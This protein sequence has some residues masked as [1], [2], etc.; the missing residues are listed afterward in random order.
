MEGTILHNMFAIENWWKLA[1]ALCTIAILSFIYK[2]NVLFKIAES[3]MIGVAAGYMLVTLYFQTLHT[4]LVLRLIYD[5][6]PLKWLLLIPA[7]LGVLLALRLFPKVSWLSRFPLAILVGVGVGQGLPVVLQASVLEQVR[8]NVI[9]DFTGE[10]SRA[11]I[12]DWGALSLFTAHI[13]VV[14]GSLCALIYFYFSKAH[15][16]LFGGLAKFGIIILMIGFGASFGFTIQGR[17]ALFAD[18]V[19]FILRDWT[20]LI[21]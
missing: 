19:L 14:V 16:G 4:D 9:I 12:G 3:I 5:E 10:L 6:D 18:R 8:G 17:I 21:T 20:G 11:F 13:L 2:D 7:F 15:T 1:S